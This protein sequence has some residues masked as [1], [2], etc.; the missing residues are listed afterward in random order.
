MRLF[1]FKTDQHGFQAFAGDAEGSRLPEQFAPWVADGVVEEGRRLPHNIHRSTIE[2]A[3]KFA[4]FQL[5][6]VKTKEAE[7]E[8]A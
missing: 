7:A 8:E 3:V 1:M 5:W 2:S 4:G 6:R